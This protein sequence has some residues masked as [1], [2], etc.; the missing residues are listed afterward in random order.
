[1]QQVL[2]KFGGLLN[3]SGERVARIIVSASND[4]GCHLES[5]TPRVGSRYSGLNIFLLST[6]LNLLT[7]MTPQLVN[8]LTNSPHHQMLPPGLTRKAW[9]QGRV[10]EFV[11]LPHTQLAAQTL[12]S[13]W[14]VDTLTNLFTTHHFLFRQRS[15]DE[16]YF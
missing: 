3:S 10:D 12:M 8:T 9:A 6:L 14:L 16:I 4:V 7:Y 1:M 11:C 2:T 5:Y 15:S 13:R